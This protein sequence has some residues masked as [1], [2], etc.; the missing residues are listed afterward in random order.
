MRSTLGGD[1]QFLEAASRPFSPFAF[2]T[3]EADNREIWLA[4]VPAA[5]PE[6]SR[7]PMNTRSTIWSVIE[8]YDEY[9]N[10][11]DGDALRRVAGG[12][13]DM[14]EPMDVDFQIA[15]PDES[16]AM[17]IAEIAARLG[18][19]TRIYNYTEDDAEDESHSWTC[20][21]SK[22]MVLTYDAAL[23]AQAELDE[24]ARPLSAYADGWATFGNVEPS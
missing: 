3:V 7:C 8:M 5:E 19:R 10:D 13:S 9:P 15:A 22:T 16:T 17:T 21:C 11:A 18:Y 12:G 23:A 24:I 2:R 6:R 14:S 20:E 4:I 1:E